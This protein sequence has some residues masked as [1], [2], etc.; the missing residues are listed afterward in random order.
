MSNPPDKPHEPEEGTVILPAGQAGGN[1]PAPEDA[2]AEDEATEV[3][4]APAAA[5]WDAPQATEPG[6]LA[7]GRVLGN[8][9]VG[10]L[11]ARGGLG[12]IYDGVNIHN[13]AERVAIK[14]IL[15][16]PDSAE[17]VGKMLLDEANALMRVR[18]DA[19]V[20]YRTYGR[21]EDT[22]EFYLVLEFIDGDALNDFYRRRKLTEKE[23]F[24]LGRRLAAGLQAAHEEGLVH[25]DV[26]PDNILLQHNKLE[27]AIL[28]DFGI[29]KM[30]DIDA[31][32]DTQFAGKLSYA[33]P[34][35]FE[36]GGR[37][38]P[39]TDVY[40]LALLLVAAARGQSL[41]MG[42]SI[43]EA[44]E[45]RQRVPDLPDVPPV[46]APVL[47][48]ML[49]P[50]PA[51][52]PQSMREVIRLLDSTERAARK[53]NTTPPGTAANKTGIT[54]AARDTGPAKRRRGGGGWVT[55]LAALI[56]GGGG[57][58]IA[59]L[60]GDQLLGDKPV[61]ENPQPPEPNPPGPQPP[62]PK[63]PEPPQPVPRTEQ[64]AT[65]VQAYRTA[66]NRVEC[67]VVGVTGRDLG[68]SFAIDIGGVWPERAGLRRIAEAVERPPGTALTVKGESFDPVL[69]PVAEE[70]KPAAGR[71]SKPS[72]TRPQPTGRTDRSVSTRIAPDPALPFVYLL[73][74]DGRGTISL[75][76]DLSTQATR[77][78]LAADG[79]LSMV[80]GSY[81]LVL[82]PP[83]PDAN[84]AP[85]MLVAIAA[86]TALPPAVA[87]PK[88]AA[89]G[90]WIGAL[91]SA[92]PGTAV[93]LM[94]RDGIPAAS[95]HDNPPPPPPPDRAELLAKAET[96]V[97]ERMMAASCSLVRIAVADGGPP[98]A[99]SV[100]G[101]WGD[102]AAMET[103]AADA[104]RLSESAV[105]LAGRTVDPSLCPP[106]DALKKGTSGAG[107]AVLETAQ[108]TGAADRSTYLTFAPAPDMPAL[109]LAEASPDGKLTPL[110]DLSTNEAR[111][112]ALAAGTLEDLGGGRFRARLVP[113]APD[114]NASPSL[115]VAISAKEPQAS[116]FS[117][118]TVEALAAEAARLPAGAV[119]FDVTERPGVAPAAPPPPPETGIAAATREA[120]AGVDCSLI[121]LAPGGTGGKAVQ[122]TGIWG[123]EDA[124]SAAAAAAS[125]GGFTFTLAGKQV[126]SRHCNE[127]NEL[128][129]LFVAGSPP[130]IAP[131]APG[132]GKGNSTVDLKRDPTYQRLYLVWV[133]ASGTARS[134]VD[135][136]DAASLDRFRKLGAL[137][138]NGDGSYRV[139]LPPYSA[140]RNAA[141]GLLVAVAANAPL[142][143]DA[144][145]FRALSVKE[146]A[147][148]LG[149]AGGLRI[150]A[151]EYQQAA[152]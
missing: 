56:V 112:Q 29:A 14:T 61:I 123:K 59:L 92:P 28:V 76:A 144:F 127:L 99:F 40:S 73:E 63:P 26:S 60:Y 3:V 65:L 67:S 84:V 74:A 9:K 138:D 132:G 102:A 2:W 83:A 95:G 131:P 1:P 124:V 108:P 25:R 118:G 93:D 85:S 126:A 62:G 88:D 106:L 49:E 89:L 139:I 72:M 128:K 75:L 52:R 48:K 8:Y 97:R 30:G 137:Q 66:L 15:P 46:I 53:A 150:D 129:P 111:A 101:A 91:K 35:Q 82:V 149:A 98:F 141:S 42:K 100:G 119:A 31:L 81:D 32:P 27:D 116:L 23:L 86:A 145:G 39:W 152:N 47:R 104:A 43:E 120:F 125:T 5:A 115:V 136:G 20:P 24:S 133:D 134:L 121:R 17:R 117:A 54:R 57:A 109:A 19:V 135:F 77:D 147:K 87:A 33:A 70:L 130:A 37:I 78:R 12:A 105:T 16:S 114:A 45:A 38:G 58:G 148:R 34:E 22:N 64:L 96:T 94:P 4:D 44:Q 55:F 41:P 79:R 146:W 140:E 51:D 90:D 71:L 143:Q 151:V 107:P 80:G 7:A 36:H 122:V 13:P 6:D 142:P 68:Q 113:S 10:R 110:L 21:I 50:H 69:C 103:A 11:I 18:H